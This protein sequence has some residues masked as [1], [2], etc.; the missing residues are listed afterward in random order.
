MRVCISS[1][2]SWM[3]VFSWLIMNFWVLRNGN[4]ISVRTVKGIESVT[5]VDISIKRYMLCL[6]K[7]EPK[8]TLK[9]KMYYNMEG[10]GNWRGHIHCNWRVQVPNLVNIQIQEPFNRNEDAITGTSPTYLAVYTC[11]GE[12]DGRSLSDSRTPLYSAIV[13]GRLTFKKCPQCIKQRL[14]LV[15]SLSISSAANNIGIY[16]MDII[17]QRLRSKTPCWLKTFLK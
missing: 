9:N 12:W 10:P 15:D 17:Y 11:R 8:K 16:D 7:L 2:C 6:M 13:R 14:G 3:Y 1:S 4:V 5:L